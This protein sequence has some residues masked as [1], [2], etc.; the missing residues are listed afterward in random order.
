MM[1]E[2]LWKVWLLEIS[3]W[4][5]GESNSSPLP[6][7]SVVLFDRFDGSFVLSWSGLTWLLMSL[8]SWTRRGVGR[9]SAKNMSLPLVWCCFVKKNG[10]LTIKSSRNHF[11]SCSQIFLNILN[12]EQFWTVISQIPIIRQKNKYCY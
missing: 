3:C 4:S 8:V 1:P 6:F 10:Q 2:D 12:L 5:H 9:K 11:W 7:E